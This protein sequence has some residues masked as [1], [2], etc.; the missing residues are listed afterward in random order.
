M[1]LLYCT[2]IVPH[3][4]LTYTVLYCTL[5]NFTVVC[6]ATLLVRAHEGRGGPALLLDYSHVR[7]M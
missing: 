4:Y 3:V 7:G 1:Y 2:Q 6:G 5:V